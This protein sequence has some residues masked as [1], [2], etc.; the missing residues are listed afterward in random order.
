MTPTR[1]DSI[2]HPSDFSEASEVA[3]GHALKIALSARA[4]LNVLHVDQGQDVEWSDFPGVRS[5]LERWRVIPPGS[6]R[7]VVGQLGIDVEKVIASSNRPVKA[8]LNFLAKHPTDLIVLAV[9][10]HHG[11]VEWL[12]KRVGRPLAQEAETTTLFIPHGVR[13]FVSRDDGSVSLRKILIA[14]A[15]KPPPQPAVDA[16]A[17]MIRNLGV[18]SG[19]VTLLHVGEIGREPEVRIPSTRGWTWTRK[20]VS[21]EP[22]EE[23]M[24]AADAWS[25][26]LIAMTT[27]GSSGFLEALRR[28]VSQ[29]VLGL[30][31]CPVL[32][33][34]ATTH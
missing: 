23:I 29:R 21:G 34:P 31:R 8:C 13:G 10:A 28:G 25:A 24:R 27:R 7:S 1:I 3:F 20:T 15:D 4:A 6:A 18:E 9:R 2:F 11:R 30:S 26:D 17:C 32:S 33:A 19:E 12:E 14:V 22:A 5:T 16:V